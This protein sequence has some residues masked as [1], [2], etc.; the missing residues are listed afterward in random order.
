MPDA[1]RTFSVGPYTV[2]VTLPQVA[3]SPGLRPPAALI[4][5]FLGETFVSIPSSRSVTQTMVLERY[6]PLRGQALASIA[7]EVGHRFGVLEFGVGLAQ[8]G[9]VEGVW[10]P[11]NWDSLPGLPP[12]WPA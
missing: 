12:G 8:S 5:W 4:E 10:P 3:Y 1:V 7:A 6:R 2:R 11:A 9:D